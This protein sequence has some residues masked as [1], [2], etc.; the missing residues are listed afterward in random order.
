[1]PH[2][3]IISV[4]HLFKGTMTRV[5]VVPELSVEFE[6]KVGIYQG[7]VLLLLW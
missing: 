5:V 6:V 7:S 4:T 3:Y 2:V 1:M